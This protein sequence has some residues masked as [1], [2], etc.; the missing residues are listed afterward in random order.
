MKFIKIKGFEYTYS[1]T[2]TVITVSQW[3]RIFGSPP[4]QSDDGDLPITIVGE[5]NFKDVILYCNELESQ[6]KSNKLIGKDDYIDIPRIPEWQYACNSI[7]SKWYFGNDGRLLKNHAW[8]EENSSGRLHSV[9]QKL[10]NNYGLF[11]LYGNVM[12][13]VHKDGCN[14]HNYFSKENKGVIP[15]LGGAYDSLQE[16]CIFDRYNYVGEENQFNQPV[17][18]RIGIFS[19]SRC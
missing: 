6:L 14:K 19:N 7:K 4:F 9:G 16:E 13:W 18:F 15:A 1:L 5:L 2:E 11:D 17:G 3:A 8:Y 12:E 10:S